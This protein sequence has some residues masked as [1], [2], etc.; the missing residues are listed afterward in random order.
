MGVFI[1]TMISF[2]I[3]VSAQFIR[4]SLVIPA[5]I[6]LNPNPVPPQILEPPMAEQGGYGYRTSSQ[7]G[8]RWIELRSKENIQ[9]AIEF[10]GTRKR[11][12]IG[13][14][15]PLYY[16]NDGTSNFS[17][18]K[19]LSFGLNELSM[20][21]EPQMIKNIPGNPTSLSSWLGVPAN[22]SGTLTI[23]YL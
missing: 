2:N 12:S 19:T 3:N 18:A 22:A 17:N 16:L 8:I 7:P 23:I 6:E 5:G 1:V 20:F 10:K 21:N 14:L 15:K 13:A 4:L 9:L 11:G